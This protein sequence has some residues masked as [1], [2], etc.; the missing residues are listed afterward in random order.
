MRRNEEQK[1]SDGLGEGERGPEETELRQ[2]GLK[3]QRRGEKTQE[4]AAVL[5]EPGHGACSPPLC[6]WRPTGRLDKMPFYEHLQD[7]HSGAGR[8]PRAAS[9]LRPPMV[10][11]PGTHPVL[12][13]Q[14][15]WRRGARL[16]F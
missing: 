12:V 11:V 15:V 9:S 5:M 7:G 4:R 14:A 3:G 1:E 6:L 16:G 2:G 8:S 13:Q 10:G